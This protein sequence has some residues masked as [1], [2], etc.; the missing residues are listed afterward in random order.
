[1]QISMCLDMIEYLVPIRFYNIM[2]RCICLHVL[3]YRI[4]V[5]NWI[6]KCRA[7]SIDLQTEY[8]QIWSYHI[9]LNWIKKCNN[10]YIKPNFELKY[11]S[12]FNNI[13]F[14]KGNKKVLFSKS[15]I[16]TV[17][18]VYDLA[19]RTDKDDIDALIQCI[20]LWYEGDGTYL[21]Q[22]LIK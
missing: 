18:N 3:L 19:D 16:T 12:I 11:F 21:I 20:C 5:M 9:D 1:M 8:H 15:C 2:K 14:R 4:F 22:N 17:G 13:L 10:L 7:L 6:N